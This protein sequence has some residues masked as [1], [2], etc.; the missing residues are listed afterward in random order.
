MRRL[1]RLLG[2]VL[3][4]LRLIDELDQDGGD[5]DGDR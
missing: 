5:K 2:L 1:K 4:I 3:T